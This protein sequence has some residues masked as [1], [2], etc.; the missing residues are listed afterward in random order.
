MGEHSGSDV[1]L[2]IAAV[3]AGAAVVRSQY[4]TPVGRHVKSATDFATDADLAAEKAIL[5][6]IQGARPQ[7]AIVGEEYGA[8]GNADAPRRWL[9]DPLC[10]TLNF[11]A[12]TPLFSV[13]VALQGDVA[14]V[15][16]PVSGETFWTDGETARVRRNGSDSPLAPSADSR[17]VDVNLDPITDGGFLGSKLL[18]DPTFRETFA[19]RVLSTTLAVA[20][21]AAGRRAAYVTDGNLR[22]SVHFTAGIALCQAAGCIVT[23]LRGLPVHSGPGLIAAADARTHGALL[24]IIAPYLR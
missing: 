3:E 2:A 14:A 20:W 15:A 21:V 22:D 10:G 6:V 13:N 23:D 8:S 4:G 9:V 16:D 19:Q 11:A 7:D 5:E 17:L 12:G 1:E 24:D 18:T